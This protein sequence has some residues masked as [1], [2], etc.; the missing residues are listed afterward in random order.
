[1]KIGLLTRHDPKDINFWSGTLYYMYHKLKENHSI[2]IIGAEV[3]TQLKAYTSFNFSPNTF[4]FENRYVQNLGRLLTERI[5]SLGCDLIFFG[6]L[7][8]LLLNIDVPFIILSDMTFEQVKIHYKKPD[9]RDIEPWIKVEEQIIDSASKII[10]SSEWIKQKAIDFYK[11]DPQKIEVVEFGANIP[12]P[13]NYSININMNECRLLFIGADWERKGG[14]KVLQI[15]KIL[16]D[17]GFPCKLTI[18]GSMPDEN[19]KQDENLIVI[20]YLYKNKKDD[21]EKL[22]N[23]IS[24]SHFL[25]LPT[26]FDAFGIV[27]CE[28][29]AYAVPSITSN[30]GGV[31]Q[32]IN[33]GKNGFLLPVDATAQDYAI[34]IKS[35]FN[36]KQ[37]Y[38]KLRQSSRDEF[39]SRLNWNVWGDRVNKILEDTVAEYKQQFLKT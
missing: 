12:T 9:I 31:V 34:K 11:I 4:L 26:K 17:E 36:N 19:F 7:N 27:F 2:E 1:M 3:L 13:Q 15:Y 21:L 25:V 33:E 30:I 35:T 24:K 29:S 10:F 39:E 5:N 38:V 14:D 20:P 23:I 22:C 32:A 18:I 16:K 8:F 6:D 37:E 28:A